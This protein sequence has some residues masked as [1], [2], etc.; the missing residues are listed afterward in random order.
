MYVIAVIELQLL[1]QS[2]WLF[3]LAFLFTAIVPEQAR[4]IENYFIFNST[5]TKIDFGLKVLG[6]K[7]IT[8]DFG[9]INGKAIINRDNRNQNFIN[10]T[11]LS[12]SVHNDS[13]YIE[14]RIKSD[15]FLNVTEFPTISFRSNNFE[16]SR[17]NDI[18]ITGPLTLHGIT[19]EIKWVARLVSI[20]GM[21][22]QQQR[23]R[24]NT[25]ISRSDFG[26]TK[27]LPFISDKITLNIEIQASPS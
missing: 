4:A 17:Q 12:D 25:E 6:L 11:V 13:T 27:G 15:D 8:G 10:I 23:Y 3:L 14:R 20:K 5:N 1:K 22:P 18:I 2:T 24:V 16:W 7:K 9:T 19:K 21:L 26:I